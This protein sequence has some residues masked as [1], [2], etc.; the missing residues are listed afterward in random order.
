MAGTAG[1]AKLFAKAD[2]VTMAVQIK[3]QIAVI[4]LN[5]T[6]VQLV[7][8]ALRHMARLKVRDVVKRMIARYSIF[9]R[10]HGSDHDVESTQVSSNPQAIVEGLRKKSLTLRR[11]IYE[12]G[13]R[14][15]KI[16]K[17]SFIQIVDRGEGGSAR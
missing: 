14:V 2:Q 13:K 15:V 5:D 16:P 3:G 1:L 7:A 11:S 8:S 10:E 12:P 6:E 9:V 17:Y 4:T